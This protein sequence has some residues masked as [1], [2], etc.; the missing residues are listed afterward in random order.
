MS[1]AVDLVCARLHGLAASRVIVAVAG[2]PGGGKSTFAAALVQ[3]LDATAPGTAALVPMDGFHYDDAVLRARGTLERKGA[4]HTFDVGGL[5]AL[6][7]RLR[8]HDEPEVAVPIFDRRLE[9]ARAAA[10]I[11]PSSTRFLIVEGNYLLLDELDWA[12]LRPFFDLTVMLREDRGVLEQRLIAR[13]LSYGF[14][15]AAA[16]E[17]AER[18]DLPNAD[19]VAA[20]SVAA[21]ITLV[22]GRPVA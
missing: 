15:A 6:L 2:P 11:V 3:A 4:P 19:L 7:R 20:R 9:I 18:N 12:R 13:W 21:D 22:D 8:A 5:L 17:K 16:R 1:E 14:D 10:S